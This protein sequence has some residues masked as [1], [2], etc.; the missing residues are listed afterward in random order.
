MNIMHALSCG[1]IRL[2]SRRSSLVIIS[3]WSLLPPLCWV[4][5]LVHSQTYAC[6]CYNV[7]HVC[8]GRT[9][10]W[11]KIRNSRTH[12]CVD[13]FVI[14]F[15][16][17]FEK[18][19]RKRNQYPL[20]SHSLLDKKRSLVFSVACSGSWCLLYIYILTLLQQ[21]VL[22]RQ[23]ATG[24]PWKRTLSGGPLVK[25]LESH[26]CQGRSLTNVITFT[27]PPGLSNV[28]VTMCS[29]WETYQVKVLC[30]WHSTVEQRSK[31]NREKQ[32]TK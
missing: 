2:A 17:I 16:F 32:T 4:P 25:H 24:V 31:S 9:S 1:W 23:V 26:K 18:I 10:M 3:H 29:C 8:Y 6:S 28:R 12:S 30:F 22:H 15:Y 5:Y 27:T 7:K 13:I 11:Q 21:A 19:R 20:G 14:L